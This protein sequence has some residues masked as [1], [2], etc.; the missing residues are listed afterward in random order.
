M[1]NFGGHQQTRAGANLQAKLASAEK[2]LIYSS[3]KAGDGRLGSRNIYDLTALI[4][5]RL[6]FDISEVPLQM[7]DGRWN[8]TAVFTNRA[9]TQ[10]MYFREWGIYA[11]DPDTGSEVLIAYANSGDSA[12]IIHPW[13]GSTISTLIEDELTCACLVTSNLQVRVEIDPTQLYV[14]KGVFDTEVVDIHEQLSPSASKVTPVDDD[15]LVVDDS[16]DGHK[17]KRWTFGN[18]LAWVK[19]LFYTKA[20]MDVA[21]TSLNEKKATVESGAWTLKLSAGDVDI[22]VTTVK[23][24]WTQIGGRY[25]VEAEAII[26]NIANIGEGSWAISGL[27]KAVKSTTSNN[28]LQLF[29][30][31]TDFNYYKSTLRVWKGQTTATLYLLSNA[32]EELTITKNRVNASAPN[33]A[34]RVYLEYEGT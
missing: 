24:T 9:L 31:L 4:G 23:S 32:G 8:V 15:Y 26:D 22:P 13:D 14:K 21:L 11:C 20:E 34:F 16:A 2:P 7:Q 5:E 27:P 29:C 3:V 18:F 30:L 17:K 1:A 33:K 10:P 25:F 28:Q 12:D 19:S 6:S